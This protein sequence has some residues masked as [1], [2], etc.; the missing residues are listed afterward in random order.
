[1]VCL[2]TMDDMMNNAWEIL[3]MKKTDAA[4]CIGMIDVA[5][6]ILCWYTLPRIQVQ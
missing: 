2:S 5:A 1:M 6:I 4:A 3:E